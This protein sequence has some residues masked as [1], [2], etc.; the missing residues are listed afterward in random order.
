MTLILSHYRKSPEF[1][2]FFHFQVGNVARRF[3]SIGFLEIFRRSIDGER[4][5]G[6]PEPA[7][8][9]HND[10]FAVVFRDLRRAGFCEPGPKSPNACHLRPFVRFAPARK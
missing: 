8:L 1:T 4:G 2:A 5:G 7:G 10:F 3:T 9:S 6:T